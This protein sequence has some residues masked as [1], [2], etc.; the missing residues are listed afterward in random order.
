MPNENNINFLESELEKLEQDFTRRIRQYLEG[1]LRGID[2]ARL[3]AELDLFQ[4][5]NELG[6]NKVIET[7][8]AEYTGIVEDIITK[9]EEK[10]FGVS[11]LKV[12]DLETIINLRADELLGNANAYALEFKSGLLQGIATGA[13]DD[14]IVN[15]LKAY[16]PLKSNQ[17]IAAVN[18]AR[19]E[20]HS[21]AIAKLF[22]DDEDVRYKLAGP[23]DDRTRCQCKAVM[24]FQPEGGH[25]KKEIASGAWSKIARRHCP[26]FEGEYTLISRGG[27]NCRHIINVV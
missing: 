8:K 10:G 12:N 11:G 20:F 22:E 1:G 21:T 26:K 25:T 27:F 9:V 4:E 24:M 14:E 19:E 18:T 3:Y 17:L 6:L 5:L 2:I 7:L 13:G 23:L 15:K 16:V